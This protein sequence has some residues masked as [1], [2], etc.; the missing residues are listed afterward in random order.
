MI[1]YLVSPILLVSIGQGS[2][3]GYRML[4][5]LVAP[6]LLVGIGQGQSA[7][8]CWLWGGGLVL[9]CPTACFLRGFTTPSMP[10]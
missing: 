7:S 6:V 3:P 10:Q 5:Y 4:P 1:P 9:V 2:V 8:G